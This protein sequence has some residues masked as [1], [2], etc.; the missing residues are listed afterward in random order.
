M[1]E[2]VEPRVEEILS[3]ARQEIIKSGLEDNI[4]SGVVLTG[5]ASA[6]EPACPNSQRRS[7]RRRCGRGQPT[8]IGGLQD[9]VRSPMYATGVGLVIFG[10]SQAEPRG[11][12]RFRI[13]DDSIFGR[14]KQ[15]MR[16]WFYGGLRVRSRLTSGAAPPTA[17][18]A[19]ADA[20]AKPA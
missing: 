4:P 18:R 10:D 8:H 3:L 14:V 13:R 11:G 5:G 6:L 20:D 9:V 12:S 17:G 19:V 15:R 1:C 16:D 2:I 7:S